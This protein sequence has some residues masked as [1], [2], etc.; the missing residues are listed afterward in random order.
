MT[1]RF[2]GYFNANEIIV[3]EEILLRESFNDDYSQLL[4]IFIYPSE[5]KAQSLY[6]PMDKVI[7]KCSEV[8]ER[9]SI[10]KRNVEYVK[11]IDDSYFL[12][13]KARLLD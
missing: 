12:I 5:E 7:E 2:N 3:K 4:P 10:D 11:W 6:A 1:S 8:I 13:G 9:H